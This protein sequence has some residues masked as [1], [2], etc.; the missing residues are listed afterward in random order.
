MLLPRHTL[1]TLGSLALTFVLAAVR[2]NA[3]VFQTTPGLPPSA[4]A[5]S[6]TATIC[7][8]DACIVESDVGSLVPT[9]SV[10]FSG[11]QSITA[12]AVLHAA[13]FENLGGTPGN[14]IGSLAMTGSL[15]ITYLGRASDDQL[16]SFESLL[17]EFDFT[18]SFDGH[19][20]RSRSNSSQ[21][22]G[23]GSTMVSQVDTKLF[24]VDGFF[25]VFSELSVDG[26]PFIPRPPEEWALVPVPEA[27]T[28]GLTLLGMVG[29]AVLGWHRGSAATS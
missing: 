24:Q 15:A 19:T 16:G 12:D 28:G 25:D 11:N 17:T 14:P 10:F 4:G 22:P 6:S 5:Y 23:T 18:G 1:G 8:P 20:L 3:G 26:G 21:G 27:G 29:I 2:A 7:L 13:V 9:S